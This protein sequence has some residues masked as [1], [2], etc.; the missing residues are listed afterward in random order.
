MFTNCKVT[1]WPSCT[2]ICTRD[3]IYDVIALLQLKELDNQSLKPHPDPR[4][5]AEAMAFGLQE[6]QVFVGVNG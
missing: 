2:L 6:R 1:R 5:P 3:Q 4:I